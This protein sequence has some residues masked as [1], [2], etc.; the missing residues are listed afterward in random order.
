VLRPEL[1]NTLALTTTVVSIG[2]VL[3]LGAAWQGR[4]A[5]ERRVLRWLAIATVASAVPFAGTPIGARCL[6]VPFVGG[7][8]LI[9]TVIDQ[10]WSAWRFVGLRALKIGGAV[11]V[12]VHLI[13][14]PLGRFAVPLL[15][16]GM[17][18]NRA[19]ATVRDAE[20]AQPSL[21]AAHVV[22]LKAPDLIVGLYGGI[23]SM[24]SHPASGT[25]VAGGSH[26]HTH[27]RI[28]RSADRG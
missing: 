28:P 7:A 9:A 1:R 19:A 6:L 13:G 16:R 27:G 24:A 22:L 5:D 20:L 15:L 2:F 8:A 14:A 26:L 23:R 10:W 18:V 25:C 17:M 3:L 12:F 4:A 21:A 11:L